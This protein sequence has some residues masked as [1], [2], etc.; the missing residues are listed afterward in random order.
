PASGQ[1]QL[2][3]WATGAD[4]HLYNRYYDGAGT[5]NWADHGTGGVAVFSDPAVTVYNDPV[6]GQHQLQLWATGTNNHLY[7][8]YYDGA[9]TWTWADPGPP[10]PGFG[11]S[12]G[13]SGRTSETP[14]LQPESS[15]PLP[16][17]ARP[18]VADLFFAAQASKKRLLE[19]A[20]LTEW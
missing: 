14:K 18:E 16:A 5:W 13:S 7:N 10:G 12:G 4:G 17:S 3:V 11:P 9:G 2:Q 6:S 8:R 20:G 1:H 15:V 19:P